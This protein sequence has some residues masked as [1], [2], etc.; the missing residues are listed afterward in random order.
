MVAMRSVGLVFVLA[1]CNQLYGLEPTVVLGADARIDAPGCA[2]SPFINPMKVAGTAL[3]IGYD[4]TLSAGGHE[5][6]F[7]QDMGSSSYDLM[8]ATRAD[9]NGGFD[10]ATAFAHNSSMQDGDPALSGD[11]LVLVFISE[12]V[13]GITIYQSTRPSLGAAFSPPGPAGGAASSQGGAGIDLSFDGLT[14][15]F[16]GDAY[17]LRSVHR[18]TRSD[19]FGAESPVLATDVAWPSLSPDELELYYMKSAG[20]GIYR[21]TRASPTLPFDANELQI[22]SGGGDPDVSSDARQLFFDSG[23]IFVMT[24]TCN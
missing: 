18:A 1:G 5:L 14:L 7:S 8:I 12:R 21:R 4:P 16:I 24:R 9:V 3:D 23:D 6:W 11:G 2:D 10:T 17:E 15:Y 19:A 22:S 13:A 20:A